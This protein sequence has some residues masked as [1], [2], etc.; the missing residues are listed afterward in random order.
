MAALRAAVGPHAGPLGLDLMGGVY[1]RDW[2]DHEAKML[3]EGMRLVGRDF[4]CAHFVW[5]AKTIQEGKRN[6]ESQILSRATWRSPWS[7][8]CDK[9]LL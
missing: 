4:G 3:E 9:R 6:R 2:T 7:R 1:G 5:K 8:P